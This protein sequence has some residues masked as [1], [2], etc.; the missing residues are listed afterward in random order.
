[1]KIRGTISNGLDFN[2]CLYP[3]YDLEQHSKDFN[4]RWVIIMLVL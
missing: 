1:M 4:R 2:K 3:G